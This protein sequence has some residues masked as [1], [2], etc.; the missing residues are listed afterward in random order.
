MAE[1]DVYQDYAAYLI[2]VVNNEKGACH[3]EGRTSNKTFGV[4]TVSPEQI[5]KEAVQRL[6]CHLYTYESCSINYHA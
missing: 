1:G 4:E 3:F 6:C 5:V 2:A